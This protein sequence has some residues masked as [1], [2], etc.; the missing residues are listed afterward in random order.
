MAHKDGVAGI[1]DDEKEER[2]VYSYAFWR[3]AIEE[4]T[5][6]CSGA[7]CPFFIKLKR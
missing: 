7:L 4:F 5:S 2:I 1:G 3:T 6:S